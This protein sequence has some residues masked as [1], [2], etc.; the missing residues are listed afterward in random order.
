MRG[1]LAL[2]AVLVL[3]PRAADAIITFTQLDD[4]VFTVSHRVKLIGSR[5]R[6]MV[7]T[8]AASLCIA[9]GY[10]HYKVL[11]QESEAAQE[12]D[13]ANASVRVKLFQQDGDDR[14]GCE[15]SA[16]PGYVA[17]A[18]EKLMKRGY[19]PPPALRATAPKLA[20]EKPA[21]GG[22]GTPTGTCTLEQIAA[23]ARAG[24]TDDKIRAACSAGS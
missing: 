2:L 22:A 13:W 16:E 12:D 11:N 24:L 19:T 1:L 4:D 9:A 8:K 7:Y 6:A 20:G 18:R 23:M 21:T 17:E 5:A 10:S 3:T 14:I 15:K